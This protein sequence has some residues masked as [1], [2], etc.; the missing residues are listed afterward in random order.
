M[1]H[2]DEKMLVTMRLWLRFFRLIRLM[3]LSCW[4]RLFVKALRM[5]W[6]SSYG[7]YRLHLTRERANRL[8]KGRYMV[9][10]MVF[11]IDKTL[12][13]LIYMGF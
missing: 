6:P 5:S 10:F 3:R 9:F 7:S 2:S 4:P 12:N 8:V 13:A 1:I 11:G